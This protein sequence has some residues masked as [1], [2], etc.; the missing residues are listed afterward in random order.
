MP[1]PP[2]Q[3]TTNSLDSYRKLLAAY[4]NDASLQPKVLE[5]KELCERFINNLGTQRGYVQKFFEYL[6]TA[7]AAEMNYDLRVYER[8]IADLPASLHADAVLNNP[9]VQWKRYLERTRDE[10][11]DALAAK[12]PA[13]TPA[14]AKAA[15]VASD[16]TAYLE[17]VRL[18]EQH[19]ETDCQNHPNQEVEIRRRYRKAIDALADGN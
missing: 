4:G 17:A 2:D 15:Q 7:S 5:E 19:C 16:V 6:S 11:K 18:L 9:L 13:L 8:I 1:Y 12:Q 3:V 14:Q 10:I